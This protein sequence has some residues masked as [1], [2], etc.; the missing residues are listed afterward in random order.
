MARALKLPGTPTTVPT[1][2]ELV[3][4]PDRL[5]SLPAGTLQGLLCRCATVQVVRLGLR[6]RAQSDVRTDR[7]CRRRAC[8][9]NRIGR[10]HR[11]A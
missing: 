5:T 4:D 9:R 8:L 3:T 10:D 6:M 11:F 1:T 7:G 2:E